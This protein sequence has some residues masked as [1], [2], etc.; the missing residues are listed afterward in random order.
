M[1]RLDKPTKK[2]QALLAGAVSTAQP[3]VVVSFTEKYP[4]GDLRGDTQTATMNG[5][6]AVD[7]CGAPGAGG[8]KGIDF[9]TVYNND[10]A[11]VTATLRMSVSDSF[12]DIAKFTLAAGEIGQ[13][14]PSKGFNVIGA[15]GA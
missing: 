1:I 10:T 14:S 2:L 3:I 8:V 4:N 15:T 7:I 5:V 12:F 6:T 11:S 13:F 9:I